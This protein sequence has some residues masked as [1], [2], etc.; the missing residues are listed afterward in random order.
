MFSPYITNKVTNTVHECAQTITFCV[1]FYISCF[2]KIEHIKRVK[3]V[4]K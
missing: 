3:K 4:H 2:V 1:L